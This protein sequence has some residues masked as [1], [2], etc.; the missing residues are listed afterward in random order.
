MGGLLF[1]SSSFTFRWGRDDHPLRTD[2]SRTMKRVF[3]FPSA[4]IPIRTT[5]LA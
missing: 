2:L 5:I 4:R 1:F 3:A